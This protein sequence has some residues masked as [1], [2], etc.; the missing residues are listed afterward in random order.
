MTN[1]RL[2]EGF[3]DYLLVELH[4]AEAT[5]ETYYRECRAFAAY[6]EDERLQLGEVD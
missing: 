1:T 2:I 6:L 5:V 3:R 4:L